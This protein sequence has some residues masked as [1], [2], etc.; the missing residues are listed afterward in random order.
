VTIAAGVGG[1]GSVDRFGPARAAM[2]D[3]FRHHAPAVVAHLMEPA[4]GVTSLVRHRERVVETTT[5]FHV[6]AR[7]A[8]VA[9]GGD[10]TT[11]SL[12]ASGQREFTSQRTRQG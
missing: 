10:G 2:A 8:I 4:G 3:T 11:V 5:G 6:G 1:V 12:S 7:H 9:G